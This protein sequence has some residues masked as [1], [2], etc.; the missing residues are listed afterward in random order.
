MAKDILT[1]CI[2]FDWDDANIHKNWDRHG[3]QPA[4]AEDVFFQK[5]FI[6]RSDVQHSKSEK[7][8]YAL[9]QTNRGRH[10]FVA[11]TIRR[12]LIRVISARDMNRNEKAVYQKYEKEED[13]KV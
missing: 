2:G 3:V 4:E 10:L 13:S 6:V 1:D 7:R 5:P 9:G 11:F 8:Y 12:K